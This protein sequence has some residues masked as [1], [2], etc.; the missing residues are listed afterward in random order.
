[1]ITRLRESESLVRGCGYI[2]M[3]DKTQKVWIGVVDTFMCDII[4]T[5]SV[6]QDLII[7]DLVMQHLPRERTNH[8]D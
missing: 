8:R 5:Q 7:Q 6:I 3:T 1:M 4:F 2:H